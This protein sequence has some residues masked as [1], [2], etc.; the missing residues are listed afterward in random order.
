MSPDAALAALAGALEPF[1]A[2]DSH[3]AALAALQELHEDGWHI[4]P[5]PTADNHAWRRITRP[6]PRSTR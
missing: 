3:E 5:D 4:T 2:D 1:L 6:T